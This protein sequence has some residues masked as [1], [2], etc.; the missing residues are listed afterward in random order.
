[1]ASFKLFSAIF[2]NVLLIRIASCEKEV[3]VSTDGDE[4]DNL[5]TIR[6][7]TEAGKTFSR[8]GENAVYR[9]ENYEI[10]RGP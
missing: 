7:N 8:L 4:G 3:G 9:R 10:V 5:I 1:M 2:I 6:I